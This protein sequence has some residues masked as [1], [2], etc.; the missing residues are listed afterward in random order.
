MSLL[1]RLNLMIAESAP[2]D[3]INRYSLSG[4]LVSPTETIATEGHLVIRMT[5]IPADAKAV[6]SNFETAGVVNGAFEPF[7][8]DRAS[9]LD[10]LSLLP[11]SEWQ[12]RP[13][14]AGIAFEDSKPVVVVESESGPLRLIKTDSIASEKFPKVDLVQPKT[15][16]IATVRLNVTLLKEILDVAEAMWPERQNRGVVFK[17]HGPDT[18]VEIEADNS[19][20]QMKALLMPMRL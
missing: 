7:V 16:P 5:T 11:N 19:D 9:A 2:E 17:I 12:E 8:L 20:Q 1:N 13:K 3:G 6:N 18:A 10:A 14:Y 4:I 15:E